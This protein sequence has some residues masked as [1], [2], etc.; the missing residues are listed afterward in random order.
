MTSLSILLPLCS[1]EFNMKKIVLIVT[2]ESTALSFYKG[3]V[4]FLREHSW[5]VSIIAKSSG[6]LERWAKSEGATAY[7]VDFKRNP[8]LI[9]DLRALLS[10]YLLLRKLNPTVLVSATPKAGLLG[11]LAGKLAGVPVRIYQLWGLRLESAVGWRRRVLSVLER[12]AIGTSTQCVANSESLVKVAEDFGLAPA[13]SITVLG[14]G[15]SH[16]VDL[17]YF[18][19]NVT[20]NV[21]NETANFLESNRGLI[22]TFVGRLNTDKGVDTLIEAI[23]AVHAKGIAIALMLVGALEDARIAEMIAKAPDFIYATGKV[24]DVR[25]YIAA[26]DALCLPTLREGFPNVV[27]EAA[28]LNVPAV[29]TNATGAIDSVVDG[30]TGWVFPVSDAEALAS[31]FIDVSDH[32]DLLIRRGARAKNRVEKD[33]EQYRMWSLQAQNIEKQL[34]L[35]TSGK[36]RQI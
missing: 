7:N 5:E 12:V 35:Y 14:E 33:F 36:D 22:I 16:G 23:K 1:V 3:Y 17:E 21:D 6:A 30:E 20:P 29:V 24:L 28:A 2:M 8:S 34:V 15:S 13:D 25:P 32:K 31:I 19:S 26:A 10:T 27:L 4:S 9:H 11:T 18:S